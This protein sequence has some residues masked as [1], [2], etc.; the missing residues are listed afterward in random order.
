MRL[1][2]IHQI[3]DKVKVQCNKMLSGTL[4]GFV[5]LRLTISYNNKAKFQLCSHAGV[6]I[7]SFKCL[8]R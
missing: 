1:L 6:G 7:G 4:A 2:G 3:F 8:S 5:V